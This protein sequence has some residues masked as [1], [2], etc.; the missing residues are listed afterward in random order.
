MKQRTTQLGTDVERNVLTLWCAH[1]FFWKAHDMDVEL[2]LLMG[3][4]EHYS[5]V[6]H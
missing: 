6:L 4:V 5:N 1:P 3:C 2:G